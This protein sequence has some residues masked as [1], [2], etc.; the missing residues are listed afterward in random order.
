MLLN[1]KHIIGPKFKDHLAFV[2][3]HWGTGLKDVRNRE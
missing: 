2:Y 1:F 3:T